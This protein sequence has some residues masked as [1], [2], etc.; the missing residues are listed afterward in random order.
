MANSLYITPTAAGSGKTV[1]SLGLMQLLLKDIRTVA[2]FRPIINPKG[3]GM[4]NDIELIQAQFSLGQRYEHSYA[5]TMEDAKRMI[6]SG[7]RAEMM[8]TILAGFKQLEAGHRFVLCEGTDF[9]AGGEAFEFDINAEIMAGLGCPALVVAGGRDR[10]GARDA[11]QVAGDCRLS[12]ERLEKRGVDV[13]AVLVNRADPD[14]LGSVKAALGR[15]LETSGCLACALPEVDRLARPTVR[16]VQQHF[17]ARVLF[18]DEAMDKQVAGY[19]I[20]AMLVPEFL[21]HINPHSLVVSSGDRSGIILAGLATRFADGYPD[22]SGIMI[23]GEAPVPDKLMRLIKGWKGAA[24]PIIQ[25]REP[26]DAV[27]AALGSL[28]GRIRPD[29]PKRIAL[30]LGTFQAHVYAG[31]MREKIAARKSARVTPQMFEYSLIEKAKA[32]RRHIVLPEGTG[33]RILRATDILLRRDFCDITLLGRKT[34]VSRKAVELGLN[35]A[36]ARIVD[37]ADSPWTDDYANILYEL[38]KEKGVNADMARGHDHGPCLFRHHDGPQGGCRRHG[39]R[40]R[41]HYGPHHPP[42]FPDHQDPS[43]G[44]RCLFGVPHVPCRPGPGLRRL[45]HQPQSHGG[46]A[47]GNRP[48]LGPDGDHVRH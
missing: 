8:E 28:Q 13:L 1:I 27:A 14:R 9:A 5:Y 22:I 18:G 45:R 46:T 17:K 36:S 3:K 32:H 24:L 37:P 23:T 48:V 31:E 10:E 39:L 20:A 7:R 15:A 47:G 12:V 29:T 35:I 42:G 41:H 44:H 43:R 34:A 33:K 11:D 21:D 4:D 26:P 30:A 2:F 19:L 40:L 25:T 38:R 16:D 6:N